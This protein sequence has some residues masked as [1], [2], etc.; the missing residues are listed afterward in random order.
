MARY[1][2]FVFRIACLL[3]ALCGVGCMQSP[4][5]AA[6]T[7]V[8]Q[9]VALTT[10]APNC[11]GSARD[12]NWQVMEK[13]LHIQGVE[14]RVQCAGSQPEGMVQLV[15]VDSVRAS[16]VLRGPLADGESVELR[17]GA[18]VSPDVQFNRA[19]LDQLLLRHRAQMAESAESQRRESTPPPVEVEVAAR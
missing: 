1:N 12:V 4:Q 9:G 7:D 8:R 17:S 13:E 2:P 15:I 11:R 10:D 14:L 3:T 19:W 5:A 16:D 18:N 6:L